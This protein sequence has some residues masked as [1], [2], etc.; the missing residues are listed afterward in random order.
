MTP[1]RLEAHLAAAPGSSFYKRFLN[2]LFFRGFAEERTQANRAAI[3]REFGKVP[4][5]NG[6]LFA[7]HELERQYGEAIDI[8]DT[9]FSSLFA[10]FDEW[11][12]HLDERPLASGKEINPDVLG[13]IFEK[14]VNQ[15]QMGAYYTKEDRKSV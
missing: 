15:K 11:D 9:A 12:W 3:E 5:L 6:G 7:E 1:I 2:P 4:Y 8:P 14:F 13:Y 10:F